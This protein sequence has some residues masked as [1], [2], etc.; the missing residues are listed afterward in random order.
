MR[1][2]TKRG[3]HDLGAT[4]KKKLTLGG[5]YNKAMLWNEMCF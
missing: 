3:L 1:H 5:V 2:V 4:I